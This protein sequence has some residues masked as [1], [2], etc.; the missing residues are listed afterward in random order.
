MWMVDK[1]ED[2]SE[3]ARIYTT[4]AARRSFTAATECDSEHRKSIEY[5]LPGDDSER[6]IML[7]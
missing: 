4:L 7:I 3:H 2:G 1:K 6:Q 5:F